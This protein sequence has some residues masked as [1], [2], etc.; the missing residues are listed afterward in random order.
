MLA[1]II[2]VELHSM[3]IERLPIVEAYPLAKLNLQSRVIDPLTGNSK[4]WG[5]L[6]PIQGI[7]EEILQDIVAQNSDIRPPALHYPDLTPW[8]GYLFFR[9]GNCTQKGQDEKG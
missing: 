7:L 9:L 3:G 6:V 5:Q 2:E 1:L 8:F 4:R